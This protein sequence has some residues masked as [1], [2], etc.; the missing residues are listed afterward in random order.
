MPI[1]WNTAAASSHDSLE[2]A[3]T[4]ALP[5]LSTAW[6]AAVRMDRVRTD[7]ARVPHAGVVCA[8]GAHAH[9]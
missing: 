1:S 2:P 8:P 9:P 6:E 4:T 5:S 3:T 7:H